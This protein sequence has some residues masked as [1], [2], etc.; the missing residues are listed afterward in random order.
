MFKRYFFSAAFGGVSFVQT[1]QDLFVLSGADGHSR[2]KVIENVT[3]EIGVA[4]PGLCRDEL[5]VAYTLLVD[6]FASSQ[7]ELQTNI[8]VTSHFLSLAQSG[9]N[10]DLDTV[11]D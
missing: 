7:F 9:S 2:F 3:I 5:S 6:P 4:L 1:T 8:A 11:A 10:Q